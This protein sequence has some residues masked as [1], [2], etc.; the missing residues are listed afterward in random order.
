MKLFSQ[1][2][3]KKTEIIFWSILLVQMLTMLIMSQDV[4]ISADE[5]RHYRQ[6]QKVYNYFVS[7]GEDKAA[8]EKT[9]ID[10]MQYNG[11][12]FDNI[13]YFIEE[14]FDV[15]N[16]M[17]MR[18]FFNAL[19]GW[20]IILLT[21][22]IAKEIWGYQGAIIA[23]LLLFISPRFIG[24][25]LNNNKDIPFAFG[26]ILAFYGTLQFLKQMPKPKFTSILLVTLGIAFA[27]SIRLAGLVT[28]AFLGLYSAIY[29]FIQ[30]PYFAFL[31][32]EKLRSLKKL[33][34]LVPP[35]IIIGYF[36]GI[37]FWPFML[38]APIKNIKVVLDATASHPVSLNQLF[39]GE[40][41]QSNSIPHYYSLKYLTLTYPLV[42]LLGMVLSAVLL[43]FSFKKENTFKYF[44][45]AFAF[46]FV[47][48]WM[49]LKNSNF[50][51]GIRHLL[52]I[53]PLAVCLAV[54]GFKFLSH[55]IENQKQKWIPFLPSAL[56][57]LLSLHPLLHNIKN[58]PYSY[59]Y[60][61]ELSGGIKNVAD[62]FESDFFQ[63]SLR[64]ATEWFVE[65]ELPTHANDTNI[66]KVVTNDG[67]N[68]SY[69]LREDSDKVE[70]D[71]TRYYE[72]SKTEWNYAIFYCGYITPTQIT[73]NLWPPKGT[74]HTENVDGFPIAAVIKRV[75]DEDFKGF[76]AI[77]QN[78][79]AEAKQHF[80]SFLEVYPESEEVLEGYA[81]VMLRE[82]KYD[83]TLIYADS[84]L[85]YNPRQIGAWLLKASALNTQKKY[86]EALLAC[87]EMLDVKEEFAE[88]QFQKGFALKNLNKPNDALKAFQKATAYKKEYY[89]AM[90]QMGEILM[91]YK[92]YKKALT[93][94]DQILK[95]KASDL[96]AMVYSAKCHHLLKDNANAEELLKSLP[97]RNQ[98]NFEAVKVKCRIALSKN[99]MTSAGRYLQMARNFNTNADL[100]VLRAMYV[101][102]QNRADLAKQYLDKAV[103]LDGTNQEAK[104]MLKS[105]QQPK[106]ATAA[107]TPAVQ[108][109][110]QS[111]QSI[112][113]QKPKPKKKTS[114][115][116]VPAK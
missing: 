22:L 14:T 116:I 4:G 13:M 3:P 76:E 58:Y 65:N 27:I 91:N 72:K 96:Y 23:I 21:G 105:L 2:S 15:E 104:A 98:N 75:S 31:N 83:S 111:Q 29:F 35:I 16:N 74:I 17:E 52:F 11:Q 57:A 47:F 101:M 50:Y 59:V 28:I 86:D 38:E 89:Q 107:E 88:G 34:I 97:D 18:H 54:Y 10:P 56:I 82:R 93:I 46:V 68:T 103:E 8:L 85:I 115:F 5:N 77:K 62:K 49:S 106:T 67:F 81:R 94:Y 102:K 69:Y 36:M 53:Y 7:K 71:Y 19:I 84:S 1:L 66:V 37:A 60:F 110:P 33:L 9:G 39:E 70:L 40:L 114:P 63:H 64:H 44:T 79:M 92:N 45:V 73:N 55:L 12:S 78:K 100:F 6:A 41:I 32:K 25:A 87:N 108:Q 61:N 24:H 42:I 51:G 80:K 109:K 26:F 95:F 90:M 48:T 113:F 30:K 20:F 43:P 112:M 99:D